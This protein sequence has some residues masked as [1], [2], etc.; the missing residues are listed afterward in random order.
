MLTT[1]CAERQNSRWKAFYAKLISTCKVIAESWLS[2]RIDFKMVSF[3]LK[4][5]N[6]DFRLLKIVS[7]RLIIHVYDGI[8]KKK[9]LKT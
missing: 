7:Y 2:P 8:W 5:G 1:R 4:F 6:L 9:V 3:L